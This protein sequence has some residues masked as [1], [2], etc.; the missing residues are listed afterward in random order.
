MREVNKI[1]ESLFEKIRDRYD[2]V[3]LGDENAKA[4][5]DP[6]KAR[7][8]NFDYLVDGKTH[9]NITISLIDETSLKVYFSK[10]ITDGLTEHEKKHWYSFLRELR[11]FAKRNLLSF[12]PRDI[13]RA[14]LKHRDIAQQSKADSTY[15]KDE[16]IGESK[17]YGTSK[18]S[19]QKFG[20]ARIIVRHNAPVVDEMTGARSRHIN[21]IY[22]ENAEGE[23][24]K[25]PF[26]SLTGA[27]AM[28]R[29]VSAGGTPHD[30]LGRHICEMAV[31]CSK[32]KP[33]MNSVRRRTFEDQE[34]Q[35]MVESAFEYHGLLNNTL[36]RM[37]GKKGYTHCKEQF[38][39]SNSG[40]LPEDEAN[41]DEMKERF[42]K[43]VFNEKMT[44]A[45]PL[46][47][48]AYKMKKENKFAKQFENWANTVAER[49]D[50]DEEGDKQWG[51]EP[52]NADDLIDALSDEIPVGV[53]AVNAINAIG[54][55]I[56]NDELK[57][58]LVELANADPTA[59]ARD[60][61]MDWLQDNV[62]AVFQEVVDEIGDDPNYPA[63][64]GDSEGGDL[65][66]GVVD[67]IRKA[68][69]NRLAD[70]SFKKAYDAHQDALDAPKT[71]A[72]RR[73]ARAEFNKQYDKGVAREKLAKELGE[74]WES[75]DLDEGAE[76]GAYDYE[77]LAQAMPDGI[78][79]EKELL[80][81]GY[82][83]LKTTLGKK[84]ADYLFN[85]DE[86]FPSD[87]VS[88]YF[89]LQKNPQTTDEGN[90][91]G[92]GDGGMDGVV[93]EDEEEGDSTDAI[94]NAI[95]RRVLNGCGQGNE[96]C[97]ALLR[98]LGPEGVV[99]AAVDIAE[100]A[101]PVHEIGSSDVSGWIAQMERDAGLEQEVDEG[102][103]DPKFYKKESPSKKA[104]LKKHFDWLAQNVDK[105]TTAYKRA[106]HEALE[107]EYCDACDSTKCHCDDLN[108]GKV[109]EVEM[110]LKD[111]SDAEFVAKYK[112]TKA[113]MKAALAEGIG[114]DHVNR[115]EKLKRMGAKELSVKDKLKMMPSQAKA[116]VKGDS[117]DDLVHYNKQFKEDLDQ[118]RR[119]AGLK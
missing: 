117:E 95:V 40:Y 109:K 18:S 54:D 29:H 98:K 59:D 111:L 79:D 53:D 26:K 87:F 35:A 41:L 45:L 96:R 105:D 72:E 78:T 116:A 85:Y 58:K 107:E 39:S 27:R 75:G 61:I 101:G 119:I 69:Y 99:N 114:Q 8:F 88:A 103:M 67:T 62:P 19:Y 86:D 33:F 1:A 4:T 108:E 63:E 31:E 115:D 91:Y 94:A 55:I 20:P 7:F 16:V 64:P 65:D 5:S 46:V 73:S 51:I 100:F 81:M 36:R 43:R 42:I 12:E 118:M 50:E 2:D 15:N 104:A 76:F 13:T 90:T 57:A 92:S 80:R 102:S 37:S 89:W 48:K 32:L 3:S 106:F 68:N 14:T 23:R 52:I 34:T 66:E 11:E 56:Q 71:P 84:T 83:D 38:E 28:A 70:R 30:D 74:G 44:D 25:M 112:K 24:F 47:H 17:L 110:D 10:N 113:E 22:V 21:S 93:Y 9:G 77:Q 60:T 82:Q 97:I 6:E 49:W